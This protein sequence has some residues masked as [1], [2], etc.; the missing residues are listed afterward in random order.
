MT[1]EAKA[2]ALIVS[3]CLFISLSAGERTDAFIGYNEN[4]KLDGVKA[5]CKNKEDRCAAWQKDGQC[6]ANPYYMRSNCAQA[7]SIPSCVG[8]KKQSLA[9]KAYA[10]EYHTKQYATRLPGVQGLGADRHFKRDASMGTIIPGHNI[11]GDPWLTLST[12]GI[13]TYLGAEDTETDEQVAA[14]VISS[15]QQG[16]NVIDTA[17]NYRGGHGER[18]IGYA[19]T[20]LHEQLGLTREML[21]ISTKAG[22]LQDEVKHQLLKGRDIAEGDIIGGSSCLHPACLQASLRQ[23]LES[24]Q[25]NTVDLLYL[26]NPAEMQLAPL[27]SQA[28]MQRLGEAFTWAEGARKKGLI[29]AY[30]LATWDCFRK[31]PGSAGYLSLLSIVQLA[32]QVGGV[33][34][35]FRCSLSVIHQHAQTAQCSSKNLCLCLRLR[36]HKHPDT[37]RNTQGVGTGDA[38]SFTMHTQTK[39]L[40]LPRELSPHTKAPPPFPPLDMPALHNQA[41]QGAVCPEGANAYLHRH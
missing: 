24:L 18:A 5:N 40:H 28:F 3:T 22:F 9:W 31:A 10:T 17:S 33:D 37:I 20:G 36:P 41:K 23:S 25:V 11:R 1:L 30:G 35:G 27:G 8:Y 7:C 2:G 39:R 16:W 6:L 13:G 15:V 32:Q 34:H 19:L 38:L 29:Q 14:A 26:H 12:L 21:F 4:F